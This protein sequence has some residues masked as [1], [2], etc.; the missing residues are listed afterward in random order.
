MGDIENLINEIIK[1]YNL[2]SEQE[3]ELKL[4]YQNETRK[5]VAIEPELESLGKYYNE[6][7]RVDY[8]IKNAPPLQ[9]NQN[10]YIKT[11]D[12]DS[13]IILQGVKMEK[14]GESSSGINQV[15]KVSIDNRF[16]AYRKIGKVDVADNDL[17]IAICQIGSLLGVNSAEEYTVY[18]ANKEKDSIISRSVATDEYEEYYDFTSLEFKVIK[19]IHEGKISSEFLKNYE[20]FEFHGQKND[21]YKLINKSVEILKSLP[22]ISQSDIGKIKDSYY[23]MILFGF[24]TN[25]VDRNLNNYGLICNKKTREYYF[26]PL[27]ENCFISMPNLDEN[28]C[29]FNG[30]VCDRYRLIDELFDDFYENIKDKVTYIVTNKDKLI[31]NIDIIAKQ[32]LNIENYNNLMMKIIN[33]FSYLE[34]KYQEK[35]NIIPTENAGYINIVTMIAVL[36]IITIISIVIANILYKL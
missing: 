27:F 22:M 2:N 21:Y 4:R 36:S 12:K 20:H 30:Y 11:Y 24:I 23:K 18:N 3:I 31:S 9:E 8:A 7:N 13:N 19:F 15:E 5:P 17:E 10:Y 6:K 32:N 16:E 25:Q 14:I 26:A 33:N 1:K 35:N 34:K 28:Q 29:K